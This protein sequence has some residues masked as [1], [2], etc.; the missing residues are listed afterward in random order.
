M[1][2]FPFHLLH[3]QLLSSILEL[4]LILWPPPIPLPLHPSLH[5]EI[6]GFL[7]AHNLPVLSSCDFAV[8]CI[9]ILLHMLVNIPSKLLVFVWVYMYLYAPFHPLRTSHRGPMSTHKYMRRSWG[10]CLE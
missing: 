1:Y 6:D 5:S 3:I 4:S 8:E 7:S 10:G 9:H 2:S